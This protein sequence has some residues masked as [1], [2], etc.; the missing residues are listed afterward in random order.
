MGVCTGI[1]GARDHISGAAGCPPWREEAQKYML[2]WEL[3]SW[4]KWYRDKTILLVLAKAKISFIIHHV[5]TL[6]LKKKLKSKSLR[7]WI[8]NVAFWWEE[9][10]GLA[11]LCSV[12]PVGF[13]HY[14]SKNVFFLWWSFKCIVLW[15][16]FF[17][18]NKISTFNHQWY[19]EL[20]R[21]YC[22]YTHNARKI[23][24]SNKFHLFS[25]HQGTLF[26][27]WW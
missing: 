24:I 19:I 13:V 14:A 7:S 26:Q 17:F 6:L 11:R 9:V 5:Q 27:H 3:R 4:L 1:R 22:K 2:R 12:A 16:F 25:I 10:Q 20:I 23:S 21:N 18:F 15:S 8:L